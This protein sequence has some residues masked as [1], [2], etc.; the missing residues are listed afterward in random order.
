MA[1]RLKA[2]LIKTLRELTPQPTEK[3]LSARYEKYRRMGVFLEGGVVQGTD[4]RNDECRMTNVLRRIRRFRRTAPQRPRMS[5]SASVSDSV[6]PE[7]NRILHRLRD[8]R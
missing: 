4:A 1:A 2:Y 6:F 5:L 8:V 3:L 7:E